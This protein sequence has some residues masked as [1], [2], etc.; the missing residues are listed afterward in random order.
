MLLAEEL[1]GPIEEGAELIRIGHKINNER[2]RSQHEDRVSHG[3][4]PCTDMLILH[5]SFRNQPVVKVNI[6][7]R[8]FR[9]ARRPGEP[10]GKDNKMWIHPGNQRKPGLCSQA[11]SHK[12]DDKDRDAERVGQGRQVALSEVRYGIIV[13]GSL[14]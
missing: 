1:P 13:G 4:L 7:G 12:G 14:A 9:G 6:I 10:D 3:F 8:K 2:Y 5:G 11:R